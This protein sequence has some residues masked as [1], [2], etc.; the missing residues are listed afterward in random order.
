MKR[1]RKSYGL[2]VRFF[3][4]GE[5]GNETFRPHFHLGLF[6]FPNCVRGLTVTRGRSQRRMA[7]ECCAVCG[8]VQRA[9]SLKGEP[10]GDIEVRSLD[11]GKSGYLA[12]YVTK[13]MTKGDDARL[14]GRHPEFPRMSNRP[15]IGATGMARVAAVLKEFADRSEL[16]DVPTHF[17]IGRQQ[18]V[19]G[20]YL[21]RRIR[22]ELGVDEKTPQIVLDDVWEKEMLPVFLY[23][24]KNVEGIV[25]LREA[26]TA[27]NA[28]YVEKL[29]AQMRNFHRGKI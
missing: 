2:P 21:R 6:N 29:E 13:K 4:V 3:A 12:G 25:G 1:L 18:M 24:R 7:S 5:Y 16:I 19:L 9:W 23:L 15:G 26:F 22:K 14:L 28:P 20:R 17:T 11:P 8:M 27:L 10:L